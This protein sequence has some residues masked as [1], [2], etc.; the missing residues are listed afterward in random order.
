MAYSIL[1]KEKI[2]RMRKQGL[3]LNEIG[4]R[5]G[6]AKGTLSVWLRDVVLSEKAKHILLKK[7]RLGQY[8]SA[9]NKKEHTREIR[10]KYFNE[11]SD[12]FASVLMNKTIDRML[13]ALLYRCEGA[14]SEKGG[15]MF[16][17]SDPVL[18][19]AFLHF[20]RSGFDVDE[21]K[22]APCIHLHAYHNI[23]RQLD[24][25]SKATNIPKE[26]FI[27]PHLKKNTGKRTRQG[28]EGCI[29]IRYYSND[30]A[31]QLLML[32]KAA[33]EKYGGMV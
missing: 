33:T 12:E 13:C 26:R 11:G 7:I 14:K 23:N 27:R 30:V 25:W 20:F 9:E 32:G 10:L 17:N 19:R 5:T 28:Y 29:T 16:T 1:E 6:I 21:N 15:L 31:R 8:T 2:V 3:S 22:F 24:F 4:Q 18:V